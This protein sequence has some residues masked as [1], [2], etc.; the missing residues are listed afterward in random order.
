[1]SFLSA[2]EFLVLEQYSGN[3]KRVQLPG[4]LV[5]T[6]LTLPVVQESETGLLGITL[7]PQFQQN[8]F[9]YLYYTNPTPRENRIVRYTWDGTMLTSPTTIATLPSLGSLHNGGILLF[10]FDG[11]LYVVIGQQGSSLT[12]NS[13]ASPLVTTAVILRLNDDGTTPIDNPF[14]LPGWERFFAY[15]IRNCFGMAFDSLSGFLWITQPGTVLNDEINLI[16]S[17]AN[18]GWDRI[19]GNVAND[20]EGTSDLYVVPGSQYV[21]PKYV[22]GGTPT[23]I[24]FLHSCRWPASLRDDCY[25]GKYS[26]GYILQGIISSDRTVLFVLVV[27]GQNFG[28]TTDIQIGPD[29]YMYVVSLDQ[30][31]VYRIRPINPMG[32]LNLDG[33]VTMDDIPLFTH[34]LLGEPLTRQLLAVADFDGDGSVTG[35]DIPCFVTSLQMPN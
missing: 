12:T 33:T 34:A 23:S 25:V 18:S 28:I 31:C 10:G 24:R 15:G 13:A 7:H 8:S 19:Q 16:P 9:V 5:T 32:D 35:M 6:V 26:G 3:V 14:S 20:P 4:P 22:T 11:K 29:G 17:G 2:N 30:G 27:W 21:D 1:M